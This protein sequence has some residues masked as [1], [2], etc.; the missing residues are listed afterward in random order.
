MKAPCPKFVLAKNDYHLMLNI[1]GWFD[2]LGGSIFCVQSHGEI[3]KFGIRGKIL[4][5][6]LHCDSC[7]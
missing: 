2:L 7:S 5:F 6:S 3:C 1:V 4:F